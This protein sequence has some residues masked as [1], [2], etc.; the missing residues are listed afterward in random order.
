MQTKQS[1]VNTHLARSC[2]D[3]FCHMSP[4]ILDAS[5]ALVFG[6]SAMIFLRHCLSR[7][8]NVM[9]SDQHSSRCCLSRMNASIYLQ[10]MRNVF[11]GF[12]GRLGFGS[13]ASDGP[14]TVCCECGRMR[15]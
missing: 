13:G 5:L 3:N 10:N 11:T 14:V 6:W 8:K 4:R 15:L 9:A 1:S 2:S 7:K 12:G